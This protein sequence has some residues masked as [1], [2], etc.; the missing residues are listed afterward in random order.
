MHLN[1]IKIKGKKQLELWNN[2][3]IAEPLNK[4]IQGV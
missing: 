2:K 4:D 1:Y 3:A